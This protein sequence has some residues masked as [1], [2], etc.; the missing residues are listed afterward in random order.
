MFW[1]TFKAT[2]DRSLIASNISSAFI[3]TGIWPY[4]P[5]VVLD[6]ITPVRPATPLKASQAKDNE[7]ATPYTAKRIR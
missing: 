5:R 7:I 3:K 2:W 6:V 1:P 4:K